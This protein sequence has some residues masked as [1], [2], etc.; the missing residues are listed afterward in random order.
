MR[1]RPR[2]APLCP[3]A[4]SGAPPRGAPVL[5]VLA[6]RVRYRPQPPRLGRPAGAAGVGRGRGVFAAGQRGQAVAWVALMMPLFLSVVGLALDAGLVFNAQR[7]LQG[8]AQGAARAGA[9]QVDVARYRRDGTAA[10][11]GR[12]AEAAAVVYVES[13]A[14]QGI[15]LEDVAAGVGQIVVT[16]GRTVE[17]SFVRLVGIRRVR[18]TATAPA[19]VRRG[20]TQGTGEAVG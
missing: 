13:Q 10:L 16:V 19:Q 11:D 9:A 2:G 12:R 14:A 17:T 8:V 3:D 5:A 6:G 7:S 1:F 18:L 20:I 4:A 15:E